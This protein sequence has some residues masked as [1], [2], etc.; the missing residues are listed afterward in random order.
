LQQDE[1]G[2][3]WQTEIGENTDARFSNPHDAIADLITLWSGGCHTPRL[4]G[5]SVSSPSALSAGG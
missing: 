3:Y 4:D 1:Q 2:Y 5:R